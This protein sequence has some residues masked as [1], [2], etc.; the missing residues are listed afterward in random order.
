MQ[1]DIVKELEEILEQE[2]AALLT[3]HYDVL[4]PLEQQKEHALGL[5]NTGNTS[6]AALS[7]IHIR[8]SKNQELLKAAIS[9]ISVARDRI[10]ALKNVQNSLSVYDHAGKMEMVMTRSG[11]VEKKA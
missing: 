9:G 1:H 6:K 3:G 2:K 8:I 5:L 4:G 7:H 10:D 11:A